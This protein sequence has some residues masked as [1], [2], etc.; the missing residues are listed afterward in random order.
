MLTF[1]INLTKLLFNITII[2]YYC[3]KG[4]N[5]HVGYGMAANEFLLLFV[6]GLVYST[7]FRMTC[8]IFILYPFLTPSGAIYTN[9]KDGLQMPFEATYGFI[10]VIAFSVV[11]LI[12]INRVSKKLRLSQ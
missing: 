3:H 10:F 4:A 6:I 11:G 8:N 1:K 7:I 12:Y 9:I 5:C 2:L